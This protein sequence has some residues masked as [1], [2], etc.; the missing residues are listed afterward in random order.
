[1]RYV[2]PRGIVYHKVSEDIIAALTATYKNL[3]QESVIKD[4]EQKF[5]KYIGSNYALA[6]PFA[7]TAIYAALK[8]R[9]IP[10]GSEIIMPPI[11][12]KGILDVV[13]D[14]D[15]HPVFVDIDLD[16]LCFNP[17]GINEAISPKTKAIIITYLYGIVPNIEEILNICNQN[18]IFV[19]EDFSQ[20][21]NG[22]FKNKKAGSY[23]NVGV[24]SSSSTKT[25]D[26]YGGGLLVCN[27][28]KLYNKLCNFQASLKTPSR[29][30]LISK[31]IT[32]LTRNLA[33]T[34]SIFHFIVFPLIKIATRIKPG[35]SIK[36]T[37]NRDQKMLKSLPAIWFER[38]TSFQ[39]YQGLKFIDR[40]N[41]TD[42]ER[43][44]NVGYIKSL[45]SG[46]K[47][48]KELS[49][50]K[51]I[52]WQFVVFFKNPIAAQRLMQKM[53]VDTSTTSLLKISSLESYPYHGETPN[54][55]YLYNHGLF[56][57]SYPSLMDEDLNDISKAVNS[58]IRD[59]NCNNW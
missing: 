38:Y 16:T 22:T 5:A 24:Y 28:N 34:R 43:I 48:P 55:D 52:Y 49:Y 26:T 57:P 56:T 9:N 3:E 15:L 12:I 39:A 20:C 35:S 29:L 23:G 46:G 14:L 44:K 7:R 11:T 1:M 53:G 50:S 58:C 36:H 13:L 32:D 42:E 31:I 10:K 45:I 21:L 4:F 41:K 25:L 17:E 18:N 27:D 8:V 37:G 33:T 2:I 54:A 47:F 30:N 6:F 40:V 59:E 51:N 19:I